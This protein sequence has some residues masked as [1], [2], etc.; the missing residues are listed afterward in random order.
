MLVGQVR[1]VSRQGYM[2][3]WLNP[4]PTYILIVSKR[5]DPKHIYWLPYPVYF[6]WGSCQVHGLWLF[7][8]AGHI[9][10]KLGYTTMW[11]NPNPT[12]LLVISKRID[13]L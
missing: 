6:L 11:L 9:H 8:L 10:V 3:K 13:L 12:H 4:N 2:T 7:V 5:A 1:V